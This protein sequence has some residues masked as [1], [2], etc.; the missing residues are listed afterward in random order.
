MSG[1]VAE[2]VTNY[3]DVSA[4]TNFPARFHCMRLVA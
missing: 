3:F 1:S 2:S 4:A